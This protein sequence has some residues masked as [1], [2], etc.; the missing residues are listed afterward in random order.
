MEKYSEVFLGFDAAKEKHAVAIAEGG[1][2]GEVHYYGEIDSSPAAVTR[3][4]RKL[5]RRH[6][7]LPV[8]YEAGPTGYGNGFVSAPYCWNA[9]STSRERAQSAS[10]LAFW[11]AKNP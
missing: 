8:C 11:L 6:Q 10:I 1:R 5:S 4:I 2:D 7:K 9:K 3:L